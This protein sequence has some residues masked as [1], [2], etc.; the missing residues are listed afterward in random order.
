MH[1]RDISLAGF[2]PILLNWFGVSL[3]IDQTFF[4][5]FY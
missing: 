1:N 2:D 4:S 5:T 3:R